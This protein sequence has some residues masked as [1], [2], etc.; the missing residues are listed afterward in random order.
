MHSLRTRVPVAH[1][2]RLAGAVVLLVV[3]VVVVV[4]DVVLGGVCVVRGSVAVEVERGGLSVVVPVTDALEDIG[5]VD[6][7]DGRVSVTVAVGGAVVPAG[8][9][10]VIVCVSDP[11][12]SADTNRWKSHDSN[13]KLRRL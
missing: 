13:T 11:H 5:D 12:E 4:R 9:S 2:F 7:I 10:R 3:V 6:V 1:E 8:I